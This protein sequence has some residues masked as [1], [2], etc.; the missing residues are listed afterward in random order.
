MDSVEELPLRARIVV[1]DDFGPIRVGLKALLGDTVCG[2]AA[3]G[4]EAVEKVLELQPDLILLDLSMPVKDG[5]Q[6]AREIRNLAPK[7]KILIFTLYDS[8]SVRAEAFEVGAD[9]FLRKDSPSD[10][11]LEAVNSLLVPMAPILSNDCDPERPVPS[12]SE[13]SLPCWV[14]AADRKP[15]TRNR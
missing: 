3:N 14:K 11:V 15:L 10:K 7:T 1:A 13:N 9:A 6:A 8:L 4:Q 5:L 2:E 12:S